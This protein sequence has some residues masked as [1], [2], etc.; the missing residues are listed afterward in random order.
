METVSLRKNLFITYVQENVDFIILFT[1]IGIQQYYKRK[2]HPAISS[3]T[4]MNAF[5]KAMLNAILHIDNF[6]LESFI[7]ILLMTKRQLANDVI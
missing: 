1:F 7:A 5:L 2:N 3:I 4:I 6:V